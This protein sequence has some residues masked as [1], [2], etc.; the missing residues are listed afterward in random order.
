M[1][2]KAIVGLVT[3]LIYF[4]SSAQGLGGRISSPYSIFVEA[5]G[6]TGSL[7]GI[8]FDAVISE[9]KTSFWTVTSGIGYFPAPD[10]DTDPIIGV[11]LIY[12][13]CTGIDKP[14]HFEFGMGIT[15]SSG[16]LQ[17]TFYNGS[18]G[19][20]D[21]RKLEAIFAS[22]RIGLRVQEPKGGFVFK[23]SVN[24]MF[25]MIDVNGDYPDASILIQAGAAL[26]WAF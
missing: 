5:L 8:C 19:R 26:G 4:D 21:S 17:E 23:L 10:E 6:S 18:T 25:R 3:F 7:V 9:Q 13:I 24:P 12:N 15:Y 14:S 11:P 16:L 1:W 22:T 2:K 20:E